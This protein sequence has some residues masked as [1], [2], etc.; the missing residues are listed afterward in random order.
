VNSL[1]PHLPH[2]A[3]DAGRSGAKRLTLPHPLQTTASQPSAIPFSI[4]IH[5]GCGIDTAS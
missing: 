3:I 5:Q 1:R 2:F 4:N